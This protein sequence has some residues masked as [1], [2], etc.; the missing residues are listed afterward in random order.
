M[1]D[2][3]LGEGFANVVD[4]HG[5][6]Y[7]AVGDIEAFHRDRPPQPIVGSE[8]GSTVCTRGVYADDK[9]RGYVSA[10]DRRTPK[11]GSTAERWWTFFAQ[12]PWLAG[13][14]VW[15]GFDYKGEPIPYKWPCTTSHFG[16]M[17]LC[18]F[19]KD[20]YYYYQGWW[21]DR[22][23]LHLFP[24]W[25][26]PGREGEEIDV[27]CFT[28]H[29]QVEL[30]LNGRS[31]GRREVPR[32]SHAA[33][34]VRYAPGTLEARGYRGGRE[35]ATTRIETAGA[36]SR[37]LLTPGRGTVDADGEDVTLVAVS[38]LDA[39]GRAVPLAD[40]LVHFEVAGPARLLGVGNGDPSSHES[41][42]TPFRRLFNGLAL[43]VVQAGRE[44]GT[45][46]LTARADGVA[47]ARCSIVARAREPRPFVP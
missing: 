11:W 35:V 43:A 40:N 45:I 16:L 18:G 9:D 23:V 33:W 17:D 8:E 25:T 47:E 20:N 32:N 21:S 26:W 27:R 10:Y 2:R 37:L 29:E 31:L 39:A 1:H 22:P 42:K 13:G 7:I 14:F 36:P 3:G 41:D 6:N 28:N 4:V 19:P 24:H 46:E 38:V 30:L 12:R 15:T 44:P 5:W 34:T